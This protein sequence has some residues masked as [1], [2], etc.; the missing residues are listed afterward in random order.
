MSE[1]R[2]LMQTPHDVAAREGKESLKRQFCDRTSE[3]YDDLPESLSP[4]RQ[5][6][7][8]LWMDKAEQLLEEGNLSASEISTV[9]QALA[10]RKVI[11][12]LRKCDIRFQNLFYDLLAHYEGSLNLDLWLNRPFILV[13]HLVDD[14]P[15]KKRKVDEEVEETPKNAADSTNTCWKCGQPGATKK[16]RSGDEF[17]WVHKQ[18][19]GRP[20]EC[21]K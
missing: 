16:L 10:H 21:E 11:L 18:A 15:E 3:L 17:V 12:N 14:I 13:K 4:D 1:K 8:G 2:T 5:L 9:S 7:L 20:G 6:E 19:K